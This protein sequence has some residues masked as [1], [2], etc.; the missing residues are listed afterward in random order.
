MT[1]SVTAAF[2][3]TPRLRTRS[4]ASKD[5]GVW[6]SSGGA[7]R[8]RAVAVLQDVQQPAAPAA[9]KRLTIS[10]VSPDSA[11]LWRSGSGAGRC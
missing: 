4:L 3:A 10:L 5:T 2:S 11:G 8:R 7:G 1:M 6:R 9:L